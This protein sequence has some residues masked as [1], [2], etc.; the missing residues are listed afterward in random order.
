MSNIIGERIKIRRE[1]LGLTQDEL[2]Q[3]LGYKSRSSINKI[4]LGNH[5]LTQRKIKLIADVLSVTPDYI[6]GWDKS[7]E[8]ITK[9][10]E[11]IYDSLTSELFDLITKLNRDQKIELK[12]VIKQMIRENN[13]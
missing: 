9:E 2:A 12:G 10:I 1:E 6:M 11:E 4:E 7:I 5:N 13:N 8:Q 3:K